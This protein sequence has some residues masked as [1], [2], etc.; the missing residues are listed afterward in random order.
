MSSEIFSITSDEWPWTTFERTTT[1][2]TNTERTSPEQN[3]QSPKEPESS[4]RRVR[5]LPSSKLF[6]LCQHLCDMWQP[7]NEQVQNHI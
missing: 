5:F 2:N 4:T 6:S 3:E 7:L 1:S